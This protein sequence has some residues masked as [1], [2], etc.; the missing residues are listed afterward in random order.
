MGV[1]VT[2]V[3]EV[4][5]QAPSKARMDSELGLDGLSPPS[6]GQLSPLGPPSWSLCSRTLCFPLATPLLA[7]PWLTQRLKPFIGLKTTDASTAQSFSFSSSVGYLNLAKRVN[8][9]TVRVCNTVSS[10]ALQECLHR[11]SNSQSS[12]CRC[13]RLPGVLW[14]EKVSTS[15]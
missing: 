14:G 5:A 4:E 7:S 6:G 11:F 3:G 1:V 12:L 8:K 2:V 15:T 13:W 10:A 9:P